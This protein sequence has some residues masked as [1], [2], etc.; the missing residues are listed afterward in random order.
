M[1]TP[2]PIITNDAAPAGGH[3]SQGTVYGGLIYVSGQLPTR[4]DGTR[5]G[6]LP[7][8]EQAALAL[9]NVLAIVAAGGGRPETLLKVTVYIVGVEHW[10]EFNALYA[11][12][13]GDAKP[14]R[15]VIPVPRLNHGAL[16]EIDAVAAVVG[17]GA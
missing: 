6:D 5:C 15:A 13:L 10:P 17:G 4:P 8:R 7:F 16:V 11:E 2:R 14:A 9:Q 3:Y 12:R 1:S